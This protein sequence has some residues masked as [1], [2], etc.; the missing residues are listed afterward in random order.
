VQPPIND[1]DARTGAP[2]AQR[3]PQEAYNMAATAYR[4][5]DISDMPN[6]DQRVVAQGKMALLRC[7]RVVG[8]EFGFFAL[9]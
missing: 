2:S 4:L 5:E 1:D 9:N 3:F 6:P 8:R 7:P